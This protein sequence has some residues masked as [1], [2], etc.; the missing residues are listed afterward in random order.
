MYFLW[1]LFFSKIPRRHKQCAIIA[2]LKIS[3]PQALQRTMFPRFPCEILRGKNRFWRMQ[4]IF[5]KCTW[6]SSTPYSTV[7]TL[8]VCT[9][10]LTRFVLKKNK[11]T[12]QHMNPFLRGAS[13]GEGKCCWLRNHRAPGSQ[14]KWSKT[15]NAERLLNDLANFGSIYCSGEGVAASYRL[16]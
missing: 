4:R 1:F 8:N 14:K 7:L 13:G 3:L 5:M 6:V 2:Q 11:Q 15:T 9:Q 16:V 10:L 12:V